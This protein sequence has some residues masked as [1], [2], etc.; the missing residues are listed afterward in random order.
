[1]SAPTWA[2]GALALAAFA[3][4]ATAT[5]GNGRHP[6]DRGAGGVSHCSGEKFICANGTTSG[7]KKICDAKVYGSAPRF[8]ADKKR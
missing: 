2:A 6:C 1:M 3:F 4:S 7:T 8:G 5:A